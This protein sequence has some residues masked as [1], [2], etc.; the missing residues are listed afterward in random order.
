MVCSGI[1]PAS[2]GSRK[3]MSM[4]R[5]VPD[6]LLWLFWLLVAI[7]LIMVA[8]LIIHHFGGLDLSFH[9]GDFRFDIGV[10]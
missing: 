10:K 5:K 8:A 3:H 4:F 9:V 2:A 7:I 6:A 1:V